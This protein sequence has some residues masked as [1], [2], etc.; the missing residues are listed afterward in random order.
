MRGV[1][2]EIWH[3]PHGRDPMVGHEEIQA[4]AGVGLEGDRYAQPQGS[5]S[6]SRNGPDRELTLIEQEQL[7]WLQAEHGIE[8][9]PEAARRNLVTRGITLNELVGRTFNIGAV[10]VEGMRLCQP[11]KPLAEDLGFDFVNLMMDRSGLNCRIVNSGTI[12]VGDAVGP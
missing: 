5:E 6:K 11:C 2:T 7:D 12:H 1:I 3:S 10:Q 9:T 4:I 8:L